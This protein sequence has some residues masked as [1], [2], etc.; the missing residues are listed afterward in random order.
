M[1]KISIIMLSML[2]LN[3][4]LITKI[5]SHIEKPNIAEHSPMMKILRSYQKKLESN[6]LDESDEEVLV[7]LIKMIIEKKLMLEVEEKRLK[8]PVDWLLRQGR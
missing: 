5:E 1:A 6:K 2:V 4:A 7:F 3:M 8:K